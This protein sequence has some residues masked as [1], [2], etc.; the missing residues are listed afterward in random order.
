MERRRGVEGFRPRSV[1]TS[2]TQARPSGSGRDRLG[3]RAR[4]RGGTYRSHGERRHASPVV[5]H[6]RLACSC[7]TTRCQKVVPFPLSFRPV[8]ASQKPKTVLP[9]G[10][11]LARIFG[12][13]IRGRLWEKN[14]RIPRHYVIVAAHN[15]D[16]PDER[17]Y[18]EPRIAR[19]RRRYA[20]S[21]RSPR[22]LDRRELSV[23]GTIS[24][25]R[26]FREIKGDEP[27]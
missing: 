24:P 26:F 6:R 5:V 7:G 12:E 19:A 27:A 11:S 14:T 3:A 16:A 4:E 22:A 23:F 2:H 13:P 10:S 15:T 20:P 21:S 8:H 17:R 9:R 18:H 1:Q 25:L